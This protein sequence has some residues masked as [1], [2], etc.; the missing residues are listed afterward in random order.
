[1]AISECSELVS[2]SRELEGSAAAEPDRCHRSSQPASWPSGH[3][4]MYSN[5]ESM[6]DTLLKSVPICY[7]KKISFLIATK[8]G[9]NIQF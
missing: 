9:E 5:N 1:M 7:Q 6:N 2:A 4:I 8:Q 3:R